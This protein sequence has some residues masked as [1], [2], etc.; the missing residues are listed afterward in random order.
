IYTGDGNIV[1][2]FGGKA[3]TVKSENGAEN[4]V[5]EGLLR[6]AF[7]FDDSETS[8]SVVDGFTLKNFW[9]AIYCRESSPT[10]INNIITGNSC[11]IWCYKST[12]II[13]NNIISENSPGI[14]CSQSSP[15]IIGNRISNNH[16]SSLT[17]AGGGIKIF[18]ASSDGTSPV[19]Q[20]NIIENNIAGYGGGIYCI[21][22]GTV[23][24]IN[25]TIIGNSAINGG[26]IYSYQS[27]PIISNNIIAFSKKWSPDM[28]E[29][30][31]SKYSWTTREWYYK[32]AGGSIRTATFYTGF[33]NTG[34][35]GDVT[36]SV[37]GLQDKT[38]TVNSNE[39]YKINVVFSAQNSVPGT[40]SEVSIKV[41][42]SLNTLTIKAKTSSSYVYEYMGLFYSVK[43]NDAESITLTSDG[44]P[45]TYAGGIV[46]IEGN[47]TISYCDIYGNEDGN[48]FAGATSD[49]T[50]EVDLTGINGNISQEP[51]CISPNHLL[52]ERS[53]CI[54]AGNP[55]SAYND[56]YLPPGEGTVRCDMGACGGPENDISSI[57]A[58]VDETTSIPSHF[59]LNQ[60]YPNPFNP[61]T[62]ISYSIPIKSFVT[63]DVFDILGKKITSLVNELNI[64]ETV[65]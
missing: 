33:L 7:I 35:T 12:A 56:S 43:L 46:A 10:I 41:I 38:I 50:Y 45:A 2:D 40:Y 19:I 15:T 49:S 42:S 65:K 27:S 13:K 53:P 21:E 22:A 44:I 64:E 24:I 36:I 60:N 23:S 54:D 32:F 34:G 16:L 37:P 31:L 55:E 63:L 1:L 61:I 8:E 58:S 39:R 11:G 59:L 4:C 5:I 28:G 51:L 3:I 18:N 9:T 26:G 62:T 29:S 52:S 57:I 6:R 25:N 47:P 14:E 20:N 48:N 17:S 30:K